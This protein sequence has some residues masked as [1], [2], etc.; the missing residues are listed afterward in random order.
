MVPTDAVQL[1][2]ISVQSSG[3]VNQLRLTWKCKGHLGTVPF[4][5]IG[6]GGGGKK[7][8]FLLGSAYQPGPYEGTWSEQLRAITTG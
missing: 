7:G 3:G 8:S 5:P 1:S 2:N 6:A 4:V